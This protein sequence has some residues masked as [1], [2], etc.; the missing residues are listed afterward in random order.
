MDSLAEQT[1]AR[2]FDGRGKDRGWATRVTLRP[3][4]VGRLT[5]LD[6]TT[7]ESALA[8]FLRTLDKSR[9]RVQRQGE[10]AAS[11]V[12]T[13]ASGYANGAEIRVRG[14]LDRA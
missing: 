13:W 9:L 6:V 1:G 10:R 11:Y 4:V 3:P 7:G 5:V 2:F 14:L 12:F 8:S